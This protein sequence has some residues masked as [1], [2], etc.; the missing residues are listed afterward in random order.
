[1]PGARLHFDGEVRAGPGRVG[2][3]IEQFPCL[4]GSGGVGDLDVVACLHGPGVGQQLFGC[5][6]QVVAHAQLRPGLAGEQAAPVAHLDDG[7]L[8]GSLRLA[9]KQVG[10]RGH[11][12]K[13]ELLVGVELQLHSAVLLVLLLLDAFDLLLEVALK[14]LVLLDA[15]RGVL[16]LGQSLGHFG[17]DGAGV[18][19]HFVFVELQER[20]E[21]GH[22]I[23]HSHRDLA[24][25]LVLGV[26]Q[27]HGDDSL[28]FLDLALDQVVL[29]N[30][31]VALEDL[32]VGGVLP[33]RQSH[34]GLRGVGPLGDDLGG[35]LAGH[36]PMQLVLDGLE[37]RLGD[38]RV[39]VVVDA[40]L[41][42]DVG[43][44]QIEPPLAG[45]DLADAFQKLVEVVLAEPLV[46]LQ[47]L[48]VEHESLDDEFPQGLGRPNAEL[49][50]LGAVDPVTH[51]NDG[52]QVVELDLPADLAVA[53]AVE[54]SGFSGE[55]P[56]GSVRR[57][58]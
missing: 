33:G 4:Q 45:P 36:G 11:G 24:G 47:P 25:R 23:G 48:V 17:G 56:P 31:H 19:Q 42:V 22:P 38:F 12:V 16:L 9:F 7:I 37:E 55:L 10:H 53:L 15:E 2:G 57:M 43:D 26:V 40:A 8:G 21:L 34:G 1:M 5:Q 41:L 58:S 32:A 14:P 50:G 51:R 13:L 3:R 30:R 39:L 20:I 52:V 54:L 6:Q 35:R 44:L 49:G 27:V 28:Q 46:Q 29:G 18:G